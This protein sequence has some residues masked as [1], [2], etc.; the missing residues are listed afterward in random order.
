MNFLGHTAV[1]LGCGIDSDEAVL[2][3][4]LPD[5]VGMIG[6]TIDK[7]ALSGEVLRGIACHHAT[8]TAF[9]GHPAFTAG[10]ARIREDA[11]AA[12]L[13]RG[14]QRAVGHAGFE[15]LLDGAVGEVAGTVDALC[16]ALAAGGVVTPSLPP[17][18]RERWAGFTVALVEGRIWI[19]YRDPTEVAARL[20]RMLRDRP[21]LAVANGAVDA[22]AAILRAAQ[23]GIERVA[24]TVVADVTVAVAAGIAQTVDIQMLE[25]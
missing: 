24:G 10:A 11:A 6:V 12:G 16:R 1:A 13:G 21:R 14:P 17:G 5:L 9:H 2:G 8:D 25:G 19:G 7:Q 15:L 22:V 4:V 3:A 20:V 18:Q 23:P